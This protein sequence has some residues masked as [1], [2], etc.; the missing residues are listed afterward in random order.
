MS[1]VNA[2]SDFENWLSSLPAP[3]IGS[4]PVGKDRVYDDYRQWAER[5]DYPVRD[6]VTLGMALKRLI[7][8]TKGVQLRHQGIRSMFYIF[9]ENPLAKFQQED[10]LLSI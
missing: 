7:P 6:R 1:A 3:I 4:R 2:F 10:D 8:G 9:P 5:N